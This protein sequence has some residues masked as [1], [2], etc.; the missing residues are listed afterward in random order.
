MVNVGERIREVTPKPERKPFTKTVFQ[1]PRSP[2]KHITLLFLCISFIISKAI[3]RPSVWVSSGDVDIKVY[4]ESMTVFY[5][6][7]A[8]FDE[9]P[10]TV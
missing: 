3:R 4:T 9:W 2:L 5:T 1:L 6:I 10:R 7:Y 8:G